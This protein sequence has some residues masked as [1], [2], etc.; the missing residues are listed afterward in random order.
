MRYFSIEQGE[1][2]RDLLKRHAPRFAH[3]G[4]A[5]SETPGEAAQPQGAAAALERLRSPDFGI[6][7]ECGRDIAYNLLKAN[8]FARLC[9]KCQQRGDRVLFWSSENSERPL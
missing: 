3:S 9:G 2:L 6:C 8:P 5:E 7:V 4:A 1:S